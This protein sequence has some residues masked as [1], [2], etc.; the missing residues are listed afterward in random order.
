MNIII[1]KVLSLSLTSKYPILLSFSSNLSMFKNLNPQKEST[2]EKK[3]VV[4]GNASEL[5]N[6]YLEIYFNEY[7]TVSDAQKRNLSN[8][9]NLLMYLLKHE[10]LADTTLRKIYLT[11][12]H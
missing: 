10:E 2:K 12:H 9:Y 1:L 8:K 6:V 5:Y 7:K 4:Y 3:V 11:C